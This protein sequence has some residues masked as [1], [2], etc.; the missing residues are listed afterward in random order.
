MC[1][2]SVSVLCGKSGLPTKQCRHCQTNEIRKLAASIDLPVIDVTCTSTE[3]IDR[4]EKDGKGIVMLHEQ[5]RATRGGLLCR[6][7]SRPMAEGEEIGIA[8]IHLES[9]KQARIGWV[10]S[11]CVQT[12]KRRGAVAR[13][14]GAS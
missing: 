7:C 1:R 2:T 13:R 14:R 10:C 12:L 3:G 6:L 5:K 9:R 4:R 8:M 11:R